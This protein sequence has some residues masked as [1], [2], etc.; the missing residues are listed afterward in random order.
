[1]VSFI[2]SICLYK[3]RVHNRSS[4]QGYILRL[5]RL[6]FTPHLDPVV[7]VPLTGSVRDLDL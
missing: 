4:Y 6:H 7:I 3:L 2:Q 1:M 5:P